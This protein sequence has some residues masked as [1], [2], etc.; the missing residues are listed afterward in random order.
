MKSIKQPLRYQIL[1]WLGHQLYKFR[2]RTEKWQY[3]VDDLA[4]K[5]WR[6]G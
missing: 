5:Y 3:W 1:A 4:G 2:K 6:E